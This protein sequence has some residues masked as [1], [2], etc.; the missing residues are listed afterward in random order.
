MVGNLHDSV[1]L[2]I[3][4]QSFRIVTM[5]KKR[6]KNRHMDIKLIAFDLDG[7]T[8][9][10]QG[11]WSEVTARMMRAALE[12]GFHLVPSTGRTV[13]Q[14]PD[15]IKNMPGIR[16]AVLSN[17][18]RVVDL[19]TEEDVHSDFIPSQEVQDVIR[20]LE[21]KGHLYEVFA[22]GRV[23]CDK[24]FQQQ[25][26][27]LFAKNAHQHQWIYDRI[28]FVEDLA[29]TVLQENWPVE[30]INI[31][32]VEGEDRTELDSWLR[33][34][35]GLYVTTSNSESFELNS[36]TANKA[37]GL[38]QIVEKL[39]LSPDQVMAFG[40]GYND[41]EML[42]YAGFAVAMSNGVAAAKQLAAYVTV[43]NQENG[44]AVALRKFLR[45]QISE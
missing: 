8:L 26:Q 44:V 42:A 9:N 41:L 10:N 28:D 2:K 17:G 35:E 27:S 45:L 18:T 12:A 32:Q 29:E 43:S 14:L 5:K 30:K 37:V 38:H 22:K 23:Y 31:H 33:G 3:V 36:A 20:L 19:E 7:T 21:E 16:Y 15:E 40:D 39:A 25:V 6:K 4:N 34:Q 1:I 11:N 13:I 24:A